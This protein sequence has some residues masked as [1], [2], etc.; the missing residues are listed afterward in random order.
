MS[1]IIE[2]FMSKITI[3][4]SIKLK[5][6]IKNDH[7]LDINTLIKNMTTYV[8]TLLQ[9]LA[10]SVGGL[11]KTIIIDITMPVSLIINTLTSIIR[12]TID[13]SNVY[14]TSF[15]DMAKLNKPESFILSIIPFEIINKYLY[16]Y[17]LLR[18]AIETLL[19]IILNGVK[20]NLTNT[21]KTTSDIA[22]KT[23]LQNLIQEI[24]NTITNTL[25]KMAENISEAYI[26][27]L[28]GAYS[29]PLLLNTNKKKI[30]GT[31]KNINKTNIIISRINQDVTNFNNTTINPYL[32]LRRDRRTNT[33]HRQNRNRRSIRNRNN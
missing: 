9:K 3:Y 4:L 10:A 33:H 19:T 22:V 26:N 21:E 30:G 11:H 8:N 20:T 24:S 17:N 28:I 13:I 16:K 31:I 6:L 1:G 23:S 5:E 14:S 29:P 12:T 2:Q 7:T 25:P 15:S 32:F 18:I 27:A